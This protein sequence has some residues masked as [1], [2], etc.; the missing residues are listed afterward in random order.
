[1]ANTSPDKLQGSHGEELRGIEF[2]E[3]SAKGMIIGVVS[4]KWNP[5]ICENLVKGIKEAIEPAGGK[6]IVEC[7]CEYFSWLKRTL[8]L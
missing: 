8:D 3:I 6:I 7:K 2:S 5:A 1:M 4:A